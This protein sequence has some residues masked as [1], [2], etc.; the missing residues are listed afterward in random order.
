MIA[1]AFLASTI[2]NRSSQ[3]TLFGYLTAILSIVSAEILVTSV[4]DQNSKAP[5]WFWAYPYYAFYRG[6]FLMFMPCLEEKQCIQ[7]FETDTWYGGELGKSY[8]CMSV[9]IVGIQIL[10]WYLNHVLPQ[11]FGISKHPLFF[12]SPLKQLIPSRWHSWDKNNLYSLDETKDATVLAHE[13]NVLAGDYDQEPLVIKQLHKRYGSKVALKELT[14][15]VR[16]GE[17]FGLLGPNGAGK[18]T[19]MYCFLFFFFRKH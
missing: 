2:F 16:R 6:I 19:L 13:R 17:C 8:L 18:T 5:W 9:Q 14:L 1:I 3:A 10:A 15:G 7:W 12:L 4:Y 11:E